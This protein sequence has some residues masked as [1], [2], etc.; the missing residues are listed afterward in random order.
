M[1]IPVP[2]AIEIAAM[3]IEVAAMTVEIPMTVAVLLRQRR[4]GDQR[5]EQ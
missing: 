4:R 5:D 3:T 2:V 1:D